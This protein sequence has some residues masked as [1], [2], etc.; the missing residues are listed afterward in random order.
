[1]YVVHSRMYVCS[2]IKSCV[3]CYAVCD[4]VIASIFRSILLYITTWKMLVRGRYKSNSLTY[5]GH[6]FEPS[7]CVYSLHQST[8][9]GSGMKH[10][11]LSLSIH[12]KL[13]QNAIWHAKSMNKIR[14][15]RKK[16][17]SGRWVFSQGLQLGMNVF[18]LDISVR[19]ECLPHDH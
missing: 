4:P 14:F 11:F 8:N 2:G 9:G 13:K 6:Y 15:H 10:C 1:M 3:S 5:E 17:L 16:N 12:L 19:S 18:V 7:G